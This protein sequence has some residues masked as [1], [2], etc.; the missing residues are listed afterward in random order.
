MCGCRDIQVS[1][2][3][4]EVRAM[5]HVMQNLLGRN[6]ATRDVK[7]SFEM[8]DSPWAHVGHFR[9]RGTRL[10]WKSE[11][12]KPGIYEIVQVAEI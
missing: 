11:Q 8:Q 4:W 7:S 10:W 6:D 5:L 12:A 3:L 9:F 2:S 1:D